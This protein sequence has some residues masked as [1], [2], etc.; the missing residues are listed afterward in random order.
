MIQTI[1][2]TSEQIPAFDGYDVTGGRVDVAAA[3]HSVADAAS[4]VH[5]RFDG[6]DT[7][8]GSTQNTNIQISADSSAI[9]SGDQTSVAV[10]LATRV[11]GQTMV[12][13]NFPLRVVD[14]DGNQTT[15]VTDG[16]GTATLT[17]VDASSLAGGG[18]TFGLSTGLPDGLYAL[19]DPTRRRHLRRPRRRDRSR[20]VRS[21]RQH[22]PD[23][24]DRAGDDDQ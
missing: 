13:T 2:S 12:V 24:D 1:A 20:R 14:P 6:F 5:Y 3:V 7:L 21:R 8:T 18:G 23:T 16:S 17:G 19:G 11:S 10:T 4:T 15:I 9:P 22:L